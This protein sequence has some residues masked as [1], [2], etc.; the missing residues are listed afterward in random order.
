MSLS[1]H[2]LCAA[3]P[4]A[5]SAIVPPS[6]D[7][8]AEFYGATQIAG[9]SFGAPTM[10]GYD[11]AQCKHSC[12]TNHRCDCAAFMALNGQCEQRTNC[13]TSQVDYGHGGAWAI[14]AKT[15]AHNINYVEYRHQN[16]YTTYGSEDLDADARSIEVAPSKC[17]ERCS[18]VDVCDCV[19]WMTHAE[20]GYATGSCWMRSNCQPDHFEHSGSVENRTGTALFTVYVKNGSSFNTVGGALKRAQ[21]KLQALTQQLSRA[22][23]QAAAAAGE[24]ARL[25]NTQEKAGQLELQRAQEQLAALTQEV[26]ETK[27]KAAS[28]A[29]DA[30]RL[31]K[32]KEEAEQDAAQKVK[33]AEEKLEM[34]KRSHEA[35]RA[36]E[37][38][39]NQNEDDLTAS[40]REAL[41]AA[42]D[43]AKQ[44]ELAAE[45]RAKEAE[46]QL[47]T[48][49]KSA[50]RQVD[51][52]VKQATIAAEARAQKAELAAEAK[53]QE[54]EDKLAE[55]RAIAARKAD[56]QIEKAKLAAA[57]QAKEAEAELAEAKT[58]AEKMANEKVKQVEIAAEAKARQAEAKLAQA[59]KNA[60][61]LAN[62]KI[63]EAELA[64]K[65]KAQQAEDKLAEA[66]DEAMRLANEKVEKAENAAEANAQQVK[67]AA[68]AKAKQAE[69]ELAKVKN[70]AEELAKENEQAKE[71]AQNALVFPHEGGQSEV[72]QR[73]ILSGEMLFH[74]LI[75]AAVCCALCLLI[76]VLVILLR[77]QKKDSPRDLGYL[78][79]RSSWPEAQDPMMAAPTTFDE[80]KSQHVEEMKIVE[81][82]LLAVEQ[83]E[84]LAAVHEMK[85]ARPKEE[86]DKNSH[87]AKSHTIIATEQVMHSSSHESWSR[88]EQQ[89][90][91]V[92]VPHSKLGS[93]EQNVEQEAKLGSQE[94]MPQRERPAHEANSRAGEERTKLPSDSEKRDPALMGQSASHEAASQNHQLAQEIPTQ[95]GVAQSQGATKKG[96]GGDPDSDDGVTAF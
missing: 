30:A 76:L 37:Q 86:K 39:A 77:G 85:F 80:V 22:K 29:E 9:I 26:A 25:K 59:K 53:E 11:A 82:A 92:E 57:A 34:I 91:D 81:D 13:T 21:A 69:E 7:L 64:A 66:K 96:E 56:E 79:C 43:E 31:K 83:T 90:K 10:F 95:S 42:R 65:E 48:M 89:D 40:Q 58:N 63:K 19:V 38:N 45:A 55:A 47:K 71:A 32:A 5:V 2:A 50:L 67:E 27:A 44:A 1:M 14:F 24:A 35:E 93:R 61:R 60:L 20:Y 23:E 94:K 75:F 84:V 74:A 51:Q 18:V 52:K 36:A 4:F 15:H 6:H 17:M 62:Q 70:Q 8:F 33:E 68:E 78:C 16:T 3:L 12:L 54:A 28:A 46:A 87:T 88:S 41:R 72:E 49:K 73:G